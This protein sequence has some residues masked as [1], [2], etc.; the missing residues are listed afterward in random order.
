MT[1]VLRHANFSHSASDREHY[2]VFD[3]ETYVGRIYRVNASGGSETWFW[4]LLAEAP[5]DG[6]KRFS[7]HA[8]S[9]EAAMA[10]FR[11]SYEAWRVTEGRPVN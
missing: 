6:G 5:L 8:P 7:W 4:G 2:D 11:A 9:R 10:A 3:G 1:L